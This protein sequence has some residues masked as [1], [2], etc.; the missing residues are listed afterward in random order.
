RLDQ[1]LLQ[2]IELMHASEINDAS[3]VS[4]TGINTDGI[5]EKVTGGKDLGMER[6]AKIDLVALLNIDGKL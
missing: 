5:N 1:L 6:E 3:T 2:S 4:E